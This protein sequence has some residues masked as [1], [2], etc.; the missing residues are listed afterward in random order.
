MI[1]V[2]VHGKKYITESISM[3]SNGNLGSAT[4]LM[5]TD[6]NNETIK[7]LPSDYPFITT[8]KREDLVNNDNGIKKV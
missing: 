7:C 6:I 4:H 8:T 1:T 2:S 5:F 3:T